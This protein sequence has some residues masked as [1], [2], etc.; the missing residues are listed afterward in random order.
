MP[1]ESWVAIGVLAGTMFVA[2]VSPRCEVNAVAH[3]AIV[4]HAINGHIV[5]HPVRTPV[6]VP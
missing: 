3:G 6:C 4:C 5:C 1:L 2:C